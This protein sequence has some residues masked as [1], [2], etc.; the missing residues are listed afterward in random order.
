MEAGLVS[1]DDGAEFVGWG[2]AGEAELHLVTQL[3]NCV[4]D[5]RDGKHVM[6]GEGRCGAEGATNTSDSVILGD[7][8]DVEE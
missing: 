4:L 6:E 2:E 5:G 7:L 8:K 3:A 1:G